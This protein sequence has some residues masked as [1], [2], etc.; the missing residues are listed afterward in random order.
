MDG[1]WVPAISEIEIYQYG[2]NEFGRQS[3][4]GQ[5]NIENEYSPVPV[6]AFELFGVAKRIRSSRPASASL[7]SILR[8][9]KISTL[10]NWCDQ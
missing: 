1:T 3:A 9:V 10:N 8:L 5:L 2:S 7:F 6:G 4:R